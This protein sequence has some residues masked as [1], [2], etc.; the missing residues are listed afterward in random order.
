MTP[1]T[2]A[3]ATLPAVPATT[4]ADAA[5]MDHENCHTAAVRALLCVGHSACVVVAWEEEA[6]N[7][8][9]VLRID[10]VGADCHPTNRV[11]HTTAAAATLPAAAAGPA[12]ASAA[13]ERGGCAGSACNPARRLTPTAIAAAIPPR[14]PPP[15]SRLRRPTMA[16]AGRLRRRTCW[17]DVLL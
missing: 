12:A 10:G 16:T 6:R 3:T 5:A 7:S 8:A 4:A 17:W 2:V 1:T 15:Q 11:T 9:G 13:I 14:T